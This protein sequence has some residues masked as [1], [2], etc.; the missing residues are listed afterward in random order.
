[1]RALLR[2]PKAVLLRSLKSPLNEFKRAALDVLAEWRKVF[3]RRPNPS[4]KRSGHKIP[5]RKSSKRRTNSFDG[6]GTIA[7]FLYF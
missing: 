6:Y 4:W 7:A 1:M 5:L 2:G 3:R